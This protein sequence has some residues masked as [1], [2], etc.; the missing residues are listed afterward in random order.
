[1]HVNSPRITKNLGDCSPRE[2]HMKE[3][4][5]THELSSCVACGYAFLSNR[6]EAEPKQNPSNLAK[7][8]ASPGSQHPLQGRKRLAKLSP[9]TWLIFPLAGFCPSSLFSLSYASWAAC[10]LKGSPRHRASWDLTSQSLTHPLALWSPDSRMPKRRR[11]SAKR[12]S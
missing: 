9:N 12:G 3:P 8:N 4:M 1:M 11:C 10:A 5:S 2:T 6:R 7:E